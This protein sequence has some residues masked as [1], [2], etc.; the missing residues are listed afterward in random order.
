MTRTLTQEELDR[1]D[2]DGYL[3]ISDAVPPQRLADAIAETNRML[4][5]AFTIT[6][7]N[8]MLDVDPA[9]TPENPRVRRIK[10]Q[11]EHSDFFHAF[12]AEPFIMELL[13]PLMPSG[14][15]LH[16]TKINMKAPHVGES[17][18]W[19]QDWAFY[20]HTND[21]VLA[22]GIYLDDCTDVNGP[23]FVTPGSHK[24]SVYDHHEHGYFCGAID[25]NLIKP[26]IERAV[27]LIGPAGTL[28]I[29]HA[30]LLHGSAFNRSTKPRRLLL[31]AYAAAD[32]WPLAD[33]KGGLTSFNDRIVHGKPTLQPR[34]ESPPVRIPLPLRPDV[35]VGSIYDNQ[36]ILE[37]RF[38]RNLD[39]EK[40]AILAE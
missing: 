13:L 36:S 31:Q 2:Q 1:Y 26:E 39:K 33:L 34:M 19:H 3:V 27:P 15:R 40:Q 37:N 30:R 18:E 6:E 22:I 28:T 24:G 4:D 29:H 9:H 16:N 8:T 17:V 21:D 10:S 35:I 23:M 11:H 32:A 25:P 7:G 20:P 5:V 38:Y 14:V 12:A